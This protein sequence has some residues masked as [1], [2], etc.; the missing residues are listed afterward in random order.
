MSASEFEL[1][2]MVSEPNTGLCANE[3]AVPQRG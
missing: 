3:E 1:L 2:Q